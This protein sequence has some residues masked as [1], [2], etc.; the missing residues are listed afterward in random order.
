MD[1]DQWNQRQA[2]HFSPRAGGWLVYD[3]LA[4]CVLIP[5]VLA[6]LSAGGLLGI[7][8]AF[9]LAGAAV[10]LLVLIGFFFR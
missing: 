4:L 3:I 10:V 2:A 9:K 1:F 6:G 8:A 7:L 5:I